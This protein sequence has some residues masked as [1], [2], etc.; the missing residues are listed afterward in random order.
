MTLTKEITF[1]V[2][3]ANKDK[4]SAKEMAAAGTL[5][6]F[7]VRTLLGNAAKEP[8]LAPLI[9]VVDTLKMTAEGESAVLS[10]TISH[11]NIERLVQRLTK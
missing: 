5:G 3:V 10:G 1:H 6:L 2:T 11:K 7:A 4:K 9:E 8:G